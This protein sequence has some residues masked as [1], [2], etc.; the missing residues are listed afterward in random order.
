MSLLPE[1]ITVDGDV[2]DTVQD[3][4]RVLVSYLMNM[5]NRLGISDETELSGTQDTASHSNQVIR[6]YAVEVFKVWASTYPHEHALFIKDTEFD[7]EN[8]RPVKEAVKAGGYFPLA[9]PTRLEQMYKI[10]MPGIKIQDKRFWIPLLKQIPQLK[11][12]NYLR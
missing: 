7:L 12:T 8:E 1:E 4:T 3:E 6:K 11:R 9:Y 2:Y 10:L 5:R